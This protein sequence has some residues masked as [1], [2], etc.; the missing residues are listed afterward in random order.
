MESF[1]VVMKD[2]MAEGN[3]IFIRGFRSFIIKKRAE[4]LARNITKKTAVLVPEHYIPQFRP[5][6]DF[7]EI[8]KNSKEIK[9][10]QLT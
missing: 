7:K 8:I 1:L 2:S 5:S 10:L 3:D 9:K 4:K 6:P